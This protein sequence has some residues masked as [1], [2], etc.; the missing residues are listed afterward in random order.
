MQMPGDECRRQNA[1]PPALITNESPPVANPG[2][3]LSAVWPGYF[4]ASGKSSEAISRSLNFCIL[5]LAVMGNSLTK[6]I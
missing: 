5:A 2:G 3:F 1:K 6:A 4:M